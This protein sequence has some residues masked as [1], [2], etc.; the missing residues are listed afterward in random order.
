MNSRINLRIGGRLIAGFTAL[1]G[2][3]AVAVGYTILVIGGVSQTIDRMANLRTPVAIE[4]TQLVGNLYSTL[5][6]LRGYLLTGNPRA[7]ADRAA[8]WKELD[9]SRARF[10]R[11]AEGF[12]NPEN[13]RK[14]AEAKV[15]L[16]EFRAAQDKVEAIAFTPD[17]FPATK[18]LLADAAPRVD[19]MFSQITAMID[20]EQKLDATAERK[21]LLKLMAD[22]RGNLGAASAQIRMYLLSGDKDNK[23]QFARYWAVVEKALAAVG[24]RKALLTPTQDAAFE[25]FGAARGEFA[26]LPGKMFAIRESEQWHAPVHVLAT[27]AAPRALKILDLLDGPKQADGTR[28]GGIKT[29]QREMLSEDTRSALDGMSFLRLV[30]WVLLAIGLL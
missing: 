18:I 27:E 12:T 13:K 11:M 29:N 25:T 20:E 24:T 19:L 10:D 17:A 5:A 28:A 14:W 2:V 6:T 26:Q 15:M 16:D 9:T 23:D 3:L 4:S 22:V 30:E 1:W 8:M 7:K 21:Q